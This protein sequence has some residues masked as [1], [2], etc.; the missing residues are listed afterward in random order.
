LAASAGY[1]AVAVGYAGLRVAVAPPPRVAVL[2]EAPSLLVVAKPPGV[3]TEPTRDP[4]RPSVI[5]LLR[6]AL[7]L[8]AA[9]F[10]QVP[11]RLDLD[12]SGVLLVA[13]HRAMAAALGEAFARRTIE[14]TYLAVVHGC[15][16]SDAGT[17]SSFLAPVER[18]ARATRWGSVRAGGKRA[19]TDYR[20]LRDDGDRSLVEC[21]PRTGRTHQLRVHL[22]EA[23]H[24]IVGDELYG[25]PRGEHARVGRFLLHAWRLVVPAVSDEPGGTF[26]HAPGAEFG[27]LP[28]P[29]G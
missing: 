18:S 10:L 12:T 29:R 27:E 16:R 8:P 4:A 13:R 21:R 3:P 19:V 5:S 2:H 23:G 15:P 7:G 22:A 11:H 1:A 28:S 26:E 6:A 17:W 14:K 20:V 24:P 9:A 25:A